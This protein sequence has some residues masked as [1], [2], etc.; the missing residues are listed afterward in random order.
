MPKPGKASKAVANACVTYNGHDYRL[1]KGRPAEVPED[2]AARLVA[3]G[4]IV[5]PEPE[6]VTV[7][8]DE[9][10]NADD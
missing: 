4:L 10:G 9:K 5:A 1:T 8:E 6:S 2:L 3:S 7:T